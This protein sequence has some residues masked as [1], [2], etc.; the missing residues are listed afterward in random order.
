MSFLRTVTG[1]WKSHEETS[2]KPKLEGLNTRYYKKSREAVIELIKK[3]I[4]NNKFAN[5][6]V[7]N[8]DEERGE[9]VL[10]K[11]GVSKSI[12]VI[13]VFKI[14]PIK[15]AV[16]VYCSKQGSF[17]DLGSSYKNILLFFKALHTE[18]QPEDQ[19]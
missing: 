15:S 7:T 19:R 12:M 9:V 2:E 3:T 17:G 5:W 18:I 11:Q 16:D 13:T 1:V 8:V 14:T 4:H 10:E 6:K